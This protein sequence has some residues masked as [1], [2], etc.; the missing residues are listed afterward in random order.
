[1]SILQLHGL[2]GLL[3]MRLGGQITHRLRVRA[4]AFFSHCLGCAVL[5]IA[6]GHPVAARAAI[7]PVAVA[8]NFMAP[9]QRIAQQFEKATGHTVVIT[10]G[11][12][13]KLA[14]QIAHGAPWHV[15]LSADNTTGPSLI[16]Q[17]YAVAG[18]HM[19]YAQGK[20]ALW[21][22][23]PHAF[24][25][26]DNGLP[27][28]FWQNFSYIAIANPRLAPYGAAAMQVLEKTGWTPPDQR[29]RAQPT[30]VL[31]QA[32]SIAQAYQFVATGNAP[33][34]FVALSQIML[35]GALEERGTTWVIPSQLY[36]P[37]LQGAVILKAGE[38]NPAS[39]DLL[40]FLNSPIAQEIMRNYGYIE[41][42]PGNAYH[43]VH[44]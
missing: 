25:D 4:I 29:H 30:A 24:T 16:A 18:S 1:M 10:S 6:S 8:A 22:A 28:D 26:I 37:L 31:V 40:T 5:L 19:V 12:T 23:A 27:A 34:G 17:G 3:G 36:A 13:G 38:K 42:T 9:M 41:H 14:A 33:I 21:S 43:P 7:V 11:A 32:S 2:S 20:L 44:P 15:L 39:A 35:D